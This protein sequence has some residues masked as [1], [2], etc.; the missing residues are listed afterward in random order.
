MSSPPQGSYQKDY[1]SYEYPQ[2][3]ASVVNPIPGMIWQRVFVTTIVRYLSLIM[4]DIQDFEA[5][6]PSSQ[7]LKRIQIPEAI[8]GQELE[9]IVASN[10]SGKISSAKHKCSLSVMVS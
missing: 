9:T 8:L 6:P 1:R 7:A 2:P 4:G 3:S 10:I 5:A